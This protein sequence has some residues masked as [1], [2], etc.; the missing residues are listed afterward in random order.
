MCK[1]VHI[2]ICIALLWHIFWG[3]VGEMIS[4]CKIRFPTTVHAVFF[5]LKNL[6]PEAKQ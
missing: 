6:G 1:G 3:D 4:I 5:F 2:C